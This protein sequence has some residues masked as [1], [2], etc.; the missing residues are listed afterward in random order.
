MNDNA[1]RV[2]KLTQPSSHYFTVNHTGSV[3]KCYVV[4]EWSKAQILMLMFIFLHVVCQ[5]FK[6]SY[7]VYVLLGLLRKRIGELSNSK[8]TIVLK[9]Q[10]ICFCVLQNRQAVG[11][12]IALPLFFTC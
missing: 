2:L 12:R 3:I 7:L 5:K 10:T 1:I 4:S 11:L 6:F 9:K 8:K